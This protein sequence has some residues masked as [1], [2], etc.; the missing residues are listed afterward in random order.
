MLD[1]SDVSEL[2]GDVDDLDAPVSDDADDG[3]DLEAV[4]REERS[5]ATYAYRSPLLSRVPTSGPIT[6]DQL[7]ADVPLYQAGHEAKAALED[8]ELRHT[9]KQR[10]ALEEAVRVGRDA[11]E[12]LTI[13]GIPLVKSLA[14]REHRRRQGWKSQYS[15]E[16][17]FQSAMTGYLRGLLKYDVSRDYKSPTNYVGQWAITAMRRDSEPMDNDFEIAHETV[18]TY[19]RIRALRGRL[20]VELGRPPTDEEMIDASTE[21]VPGGLHMGRVSRQGRHAALSQEI[22][23]QERMYQHRVGI[24]GR[25]E[26]D[27]TDNEESDAQK[28][29]FEAATPIAGAHLP[30]PDDVIDEHT[31]TGTAR[32]LTATMDALNM[33][34]DQREIIA[35]RFALEPFTAEHSYRDCGKAMNVNMNAVQLVVETFQAQMSQPQGVFHYQL[36][37]VD[38]DDVVEMG[39]AWAL[40]LLGD[41]VGPVVYPTNPA[42]LTEPLPRKKSAPLPPRAAMAEGIQAVYECTFHKTMFIAWYVEMAHVPQTRACPRCGNASTFQ[43]VR[44]S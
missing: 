38:R 9:A 18:E 37:L 14:M 15:F 28:S 32:L 11:Q 30:T 36:S 43:Q 35:R 17:L 31:R 24:T 33:G 26:N 21:A 1:D 2:V 20:T 25:Q 40:D 23:D 13:A 44:E 19:R 8:P 12:R 42:V 10:A 7:R 41:F 16:D 5:A 39:M 34:V 29:S 22:L 27:D 4:V 6:M 3:E